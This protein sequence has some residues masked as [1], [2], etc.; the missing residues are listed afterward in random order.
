MPASRSTIERATTFGALDSTAFVDGAP[1]SAHL[2]RELARSLNLRL[3]A[4]E[5]VASMVWNA[6]TG[7]EADA[8]GYTGLDGKLLGFGMPY[9]THVAP[10]LEV[11]KKAGLAHY[12]L[13]VTAYIP[14]DQVVRWGLQTRRQPRIQ[15][16]GALVLEATG[17]GDWAN[18][19]LENI[20]AN[21]GGS[22]SLDFLARGDAYVLMADAYGT[23]KTGTVNTMMLNAFQATTADLDPLVAGRNWVRFTRSDGCPLTDPKVID[24]WVA[25]DTLQF[26]PPVDASELD[27]LQGATYTIYALPRWHLA[28]I[29]V[30]ATE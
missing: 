21:P 28:S 7:V 6:R 17:T 25:S 27:W 10:S 2:L 11:P 4:P 26:W 29:Y 18:Y 22:D 14:L 20:P 23:G 1:V 5:P 24:G 8:D 9:W 30:L 12:S 19:L 16:Q 3:Y 15:D 13:A